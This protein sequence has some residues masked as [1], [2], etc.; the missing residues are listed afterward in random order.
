VAD[1]QVVVD[2]ACR[3]APGLPVQ[4]LARRAERVRAT[5]E[6]LRRG[7]L[8]ISRKNLYEKLARQKKN[9]TK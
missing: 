1:E 9:E 8:G 3:E 7:T 2:P 6:H 4:P 5:R